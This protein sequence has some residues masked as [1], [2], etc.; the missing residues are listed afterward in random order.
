MQPAGP[1][2]WVIRP[3]DGLRV[4]TAIEPGLPETLGATPEL[5]AYTVR[6]SGETASASGPFNARAS[7]QIPSVTSWLTHA[8]GP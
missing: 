8:P 5:A 6:P 4:N 2:G 1:A 7:A 3:V